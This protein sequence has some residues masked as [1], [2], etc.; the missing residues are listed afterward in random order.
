VFFLPGKPE[1]FFPMMAV[2]L[3]IS[4]LQRTMN[5]DKRFIPAPEIT[6]PL[7]CMMLVVLGTAKLTGG[8]GLHSLGNS[9]MGGRK[10]IELMAGILGYFAF[11]ARRIPHHQA[12]LYVALFLLGPCINVL[13]DL[14]TFIPSS[15]YFMYLFV[16]PDSYTMTGSTG[17][18]RF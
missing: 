13:G 6:W 12:G 14:V 1:A 4:T 15:F 9:T 8:I 17:S 7:L 16:Q 18:M 11:T 5:K 10:Y 2:S 3:G